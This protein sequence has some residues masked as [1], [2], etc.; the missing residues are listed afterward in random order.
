MGILESLLASSGHGIGGNG[1]GTNGN[2]GN[3]KSE[4]Q[5]VFNGG[6]SLIHLLPILLTT[7]TD[8]IKLLVL[9]LIPKLTHLFGSLLAHKIDD[10]IMAF[11][12]ISNKELLKVFTR[13]I[14]ALEKME[15][16][17]SMMSRKWVDFMERMKKNPMIMEY[18]VLA[19][20][21]N[22]DY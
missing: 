13:A 21:E 7:D 3:G 22:A 10:F 1:N 17:K 5:K 15:E 12:K 6:E 8:E 18:L 19:Q 2:N 20:T 11:D 9:Q 14:V 16:M 4:I